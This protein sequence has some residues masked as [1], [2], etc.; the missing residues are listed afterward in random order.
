M[1]YYHPHPYIYLPIYPS[2]FLPTNTLSR[3]LPNPT[4]IGY[5]YLHGCHPNKPPMVEN[6][7][8]RIK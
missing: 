2:T 4:Y 6:D 7:E 1:C 8:E 3:Y 5:T